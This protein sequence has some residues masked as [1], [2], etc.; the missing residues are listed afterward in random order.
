MGAVA[1]A[2]MVTFYYHVHYHCLLQ[3]WEFQ[4]ENGCRP[5]CPNCHYSHTDETLVQL[6]FLDADRAVMRAA[7][8]GMRAALGSPVVAALPA[9]ALRSTTLTLYLSCSRV[10]R[11]RARPAPCD[12]QSFRAQTEREYVRVH[13]LRGFVAFGL[14]A[15]FFE[16]AQNYDVCV[17][18]SRGRRRLTGTL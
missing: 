16:E 9:A 17:V 1:D 18:S 2:P 14:A 7:L 13:G 11:A 15:R 6:G 10:Q 5:L 8:G 4:M 3:W 12:V